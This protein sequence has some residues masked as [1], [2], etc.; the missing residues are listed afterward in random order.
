MVLLQTQHQ[1]RPQDAQDTLQEGGWRVVMAVG[2]TAQ[3]TDFGGQTEEMKEEF[4]E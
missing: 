2:K 3:I 1:T 4:P